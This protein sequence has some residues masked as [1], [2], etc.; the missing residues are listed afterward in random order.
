ML[1]LLPMPVCAVD[2]SESSWPRREPG[3][4]SVQ[5]GSTSV[6]PAAMGAAHGP[7]SAKCGASEMKLLSAFF[8]LASRFET[9]ESMRKASCASEMASCISGGTLNVLSP[10]EP[11]GLAG[12]ARKPPSCGNAASAELRADSTPV[13][14]LRLPPPPKLALAPALPWHPLHPTVRNR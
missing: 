7:E 10:N 3:P 9:S 1:R 13:L 8:E 4:P 6:S 5:F 14:K 2:S 12:E 11:S